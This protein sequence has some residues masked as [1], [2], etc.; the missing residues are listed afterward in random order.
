MEIKLLQIK[1]FITISTYPWLKVLFFFFT[2]ENGWR[3]LGEEGIERNQQQKLGILL[4][5]SREK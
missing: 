3:L 5:E 1:F 2:K 4:W